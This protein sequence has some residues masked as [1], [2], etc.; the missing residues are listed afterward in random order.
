MRLIVNVV[1]KFIDPFR[2]FKAEDLLL[3]IQKSARRLEAYARDLQDRLVVDIY[4][5][6]DHIKHTADNVQVQVKEIRQSLSDV[7]QD[8]R[9]IS[10]Q[11][12]EIMGSQ[13]ED[14]KQFCA[15]QI[16]YALESKNGLFQMLTEFVSGNHLPLV[17]RKEILLTGETYSSAIYRVGAKI[18]PPRF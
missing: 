3:C 14:L 6:T 8:V 1:A 15:R 7:H 10:V 5:D 11:C 17:I 18:G 4:H 9:G 2:G 13:I 16:D 12:E